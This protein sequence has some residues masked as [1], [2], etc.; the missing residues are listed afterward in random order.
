MTGAS[1]ARG[2]KVTSWCACAWITLPHT[3]IASQRLLTFQVTEF[4]DIWHL[5][6]MHSSLLLILFLTY[7]ILLHCQLASPMYFPALKVLFM[8]STAG[9]WKLCLWHSSCAFRFSENTFK[10]TCKF[11][12]WFLSNHY[13]QTI[14]L[15]F[16]TGVFNEVSYSKI[17]FQKGKGKKKHKNAIHVFCKNYN[18]KWINK[19]STRRF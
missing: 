5:V 1:W 12:Y 11:P 18:I 4:S 2:Y 9:I 19:K 15:C 8:E 16:N 10:V 6:M 7:N 17:N 13:V 3:H 14:N